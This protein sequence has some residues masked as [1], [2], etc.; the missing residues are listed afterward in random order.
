MY[1]N[2]T[3]YYTGIFIFIEIKE[4][5]LKIFHSAF[6]V[7]WIVNQL[8][9]YWIKISDTLFRNWQAVL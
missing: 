4:K 3:L 1:F 6:K 5:Y 8:R 7:N 2:S 9:G